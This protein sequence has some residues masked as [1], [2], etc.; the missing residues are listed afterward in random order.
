MEDMARVRYWA[1][2]R[3]AAGT[4]EQVID[5]P[6]LGSVLAGIRHQHGESMTRLLDRCV[7]LV[8]GAQ[9]TREDDPILDPDALVEVLPPYAGGAQ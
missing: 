3:A 2:A 7:L 5:G 1:G 8:D 4:D 6:T 9:V